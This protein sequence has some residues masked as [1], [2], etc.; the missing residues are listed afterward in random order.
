MSQSDLIIE[1]QSGVSFRQDVQEAL[2]AV[3]SN[4][5]GPIQPSVTYAGQTWYDT[6]NDLWKIRNKNNNG[7]ITISELDSNVNLNE[8]RSEVVRSSSQRGVA[9]QSNEGVELLRI[10]QDGNA[11]GL[12]VATAAEIAAETSGTKLI[13]DSSMR[14]AIQSE[15]IWEYE[16]SETVIN[17]GLRNSTEFIHNLG[18]KPSLV[19]IDMICVS[20]DTGFIPGDIILSI[21][22]S[23]SANFGAGLVIS[24]RSMDKIS[25][26][27]DDRF[28]HI[29]TVHQSTFLDHTKWRY[30]LKAR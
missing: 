29:P 28:V 4:S 19:Q 5:I 2:Q 17:V 18:R 25:V 24:M 27:A 12:G 13:T 8:P 3:G 1:N 20:S 15:N 16:S 10:S 9:L 30:I 11:S 21:G 14:K 26:R 7:W 22:S 23:T 6:T